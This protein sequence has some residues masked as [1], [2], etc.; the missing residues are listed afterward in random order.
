MT[1]TRRITEHP[2]RTLVQLCANTIHPAPLK[3]VSKTV[4]STL[5]HVVKAAYWAWMVAYR[6]HSR[7]AGGNAE[8]HP[9]KSC[10]SDLEGPLHRASATSRG[11]SP[12]TQGSG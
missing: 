11:L 12:S 7:E 4:Q 10:G 9:N 3:S 2:V 1:T 8:D 6:S 5:S